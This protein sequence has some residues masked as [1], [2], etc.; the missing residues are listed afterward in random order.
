MGE[1]RVA[2]AEEGFYEAY[3]VDTKLDITVAGPFRY[4][5]EAVYEARM[6]ERDAM[7]AEDDSARLLKAEYHVQATHF[8]EIKYI[9]D[10]PPTMKVSRVRLRRRTI[11]TSSGGCCMCSGTRTVTAFEYEPTAEEN[12]DG[13]DYK[14]PDREYIDG[15]LVT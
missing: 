10:G 9:E 2:V 5:E 6:L 3:V 12:G 13:M 14:W 8:W 4:V 7:E 1:T 11:S 15:E